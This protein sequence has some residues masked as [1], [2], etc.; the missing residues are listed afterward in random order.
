MKD[1]GKK[2][3]AAKAAKQAVFGKQLIKVNDEWSIARIDEY[4]WQIR[5]KTLPYP[6]AQPW[7]FGT[8]Q[9]AF[10]ALPEKMLDEEAKNSM[11]EAQRDYRRFLEVV[12]K[13][14]GKIGVDTNR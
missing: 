1:K 9:G 2:I 7:Y 12:E 14:L 10:V 4:N 8:L 6:K 13:T 3:Q 11:A 5:K